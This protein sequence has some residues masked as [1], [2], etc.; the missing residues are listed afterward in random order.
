MRI[1]EINL[2]RLVILYM[3]QFFDR[4]TPFSFR[5]HRKKVSE[6]KLRVCL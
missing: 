2:Y 1:K 6:F 3:Y 4:Y 5:G